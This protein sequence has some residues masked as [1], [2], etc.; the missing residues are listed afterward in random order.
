MNADLNEQEQF[1]E[2]CFYTLS[3][4]DPAFIHQYAVDAFA[5]QH[6]SAESKPVSITFAL[7][8][9]Y[10]HLEHGY[11]GREV[12]LAHMHLARPPRRQWPRL[13]PPQQRGDM[14]VGDILAAAPGTERDRALDEWCRSVWETWQHA[15]GEIIQLCDELLPAS[16][17]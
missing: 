13:P 11:T 2:L 15:R 10:L 3:H 12:Q 6:A 9:L 4:G 1:D 8:G 16:R 5:A 17:V 14:R 7:I